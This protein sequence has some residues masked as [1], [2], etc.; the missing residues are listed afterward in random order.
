MKSNLNSLQ[1][2]SNSALHNDLDPSSS[3]F[4]NTLCKPI[5]PLAPLDMIFFRNTSNNLPTCSGSYLCFFGFDYPTDLP[6]NTI[7]ENSL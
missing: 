6:P 4:L 1:A 3:I 2:F 5:M 7:D